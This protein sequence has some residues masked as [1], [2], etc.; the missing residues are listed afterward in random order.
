MTL[1]IEQGLDFGWGE[2]V[3]EPNRHGAPTRDTKGT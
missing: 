2:D 1:S 3:R